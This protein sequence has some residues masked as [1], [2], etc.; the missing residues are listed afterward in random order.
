MSGTET[1]YAATRCPHCRKFFE[2]NPDDF[3]NKVD[4]ALRAQDAGRRVCSRALPQPPPL[5]LTSSPQKNVWR[6]SSAGTRG[7][8][9]SLVSCSTMS[10]KPA[11]RSCARCT[12]HSSLFRLGLPCDASPFTLKSRENLHPSRVTLESRC[13]TSCSKVCTT[14][15]RCFEGASTT[16]MMGMGGDLKQAG[17]GLAGA[18]GIAGEAAQAAR[19]SRFA[20][21][22]V[23]HSLT[24]SLSHTHRPALTH[25]HTVQTCI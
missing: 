5:F 18:E 10:A 12:P 24:H 8:R 21:R 22:Q 14:V 11:S 15:W 7:A 1:G 3:H 4:L 9:G 16:S 23:A 6:R 25:T 13:T 2:Y 19:G 20:Q 17:C